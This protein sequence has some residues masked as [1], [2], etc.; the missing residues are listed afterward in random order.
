VQARARALCQQIGKTPQRFT[1]L[2]GL[3]GFYATRGALQTA[4]V[5]AE[6]LFE[7]AQ[8]LHNPALLCPATYMMGGICLFLGE[9]TTART[10]LEQGMVL[11][12]PQR[13]QAYAVMHG[14]TRLYPAP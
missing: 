13:H 7:L 11:Y 14:V 9:L 6:Q 2:W 3:C 5:L 8:R 12:E 1:V 4:R 10:Y